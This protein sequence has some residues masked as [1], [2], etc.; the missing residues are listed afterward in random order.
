M[1]L[2]EV[3]GVLKSIVEGQIPWNYCVLLLAWL[4]ITAVVTCER[5]WHGV[6]HGAAAAALFSAIAI[7]FELAYRRWLTHAPVTQQ[8]THKRSAGARRKCAQRPCGPG[9][10]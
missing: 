5:N 3:S 8:C 2:K 4:L 7:G 9:A 1:Q 6:L 10:P